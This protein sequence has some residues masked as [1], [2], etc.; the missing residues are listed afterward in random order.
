M[1]DYLPIERDL[2]ASAVEENFASH[3]AKDCNGEE[4]VD[5]SK[6]MTGHA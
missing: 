5:E 4:V 1:E 2:A 6:K 3:V